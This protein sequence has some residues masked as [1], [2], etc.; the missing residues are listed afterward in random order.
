M[1]LN[2]L[3]DLWDESHAKTIDPAGL[4]RHRSNLLGSDLRVTNFGAS[5]NTPLHA[6]LPFAHVDYLHPNWGIALAASTN[7]K[8]KMDEFQKFGHKMVR[9]PS[10]RP[11]FELAMM[12]DRAVK[13]LPGCDRVLLGGHGLFTSGTHPARIVSQYH[14]IVD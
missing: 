8:E 4:S 12:L 2:Y 5:I 3:T 6:F 14:R 7:G 9:L 1:F 10:Q 11:G 13:E